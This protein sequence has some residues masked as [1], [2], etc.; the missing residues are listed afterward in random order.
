MPSLDFYRDSMS[1]DAR[2][3]FGGRLSL[4]H[5]LAGASLES[6]AACLG[7]KR[8]RVRAWESDRAEPSTRQIFLLAAFLRVS[9][10][11]LMTGIGEGPVDEDGER[12]MLAVKSQR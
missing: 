5:D 12:E 10:M 8:Q 9:P 4:A 2:D 6:L 7:V 3:T 11:W 1:E